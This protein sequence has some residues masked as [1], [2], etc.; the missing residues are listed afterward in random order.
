MDFGVNGCAIA[1]AFGA[2]IGRRDCG[3]VTGGIIAIDVFCQTY[4]KIFRTT[5]DKA[6]I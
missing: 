4:E 3:A 2:G 5:L 6:F 1:T